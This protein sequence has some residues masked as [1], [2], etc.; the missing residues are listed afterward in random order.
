ML[1]LMYP[2]IIGMLIVSFAKKSAN[3]FQ[4]LQSF[5]VF[6]ISE[7][8]SSHDW[9]LGLR[10]SSPGCQHCYR[11]RLVTHPSSIYAHL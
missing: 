2:R 5:I 4:L 10:G 1:Y 8:A 6:I 7:E 9:C 11:P 3:F